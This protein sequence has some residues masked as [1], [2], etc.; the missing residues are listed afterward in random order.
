M[1]SERKAKGG[2]GKIINNSG[3]ETRGKNQLIIWPE[4]GRFNTNIRCLPYLWSLLRLPRTMFS[5]RGT[6]FSERGIKDS[7]GRSL[8]DLKLK[9]TIFKY[10]CSYM[11]YSKSFVSLPDVLK[12]AVFKRIKDILNNRIK[13]KEYDYISSETKIELLEILNETVPGFVKLS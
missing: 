9:D 7:K 11:I 12:S 3:E 1:G 8:R 13:T 10:S 5:D 6:L 4:G 2:K